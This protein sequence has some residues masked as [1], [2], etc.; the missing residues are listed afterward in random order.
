MTKAELEAKL[1]EMEMRALEN[2][3]AACS[4]ASRARQAELQSLEY[5]GREI[6]AK[7]QELNEPAKS[8]E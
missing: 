2:E 7:I 6:K 1:R 8:D 3:L 5:R 4:E